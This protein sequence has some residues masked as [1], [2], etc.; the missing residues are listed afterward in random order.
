MFFAG[1]WQAADGPVAAQSSSSEHSSEAKS[2]SATSVSAAEPPATD[3]ATAT[4]PDADQQTQPEARSEPASA[5]MA[6]RAAL[7]AAAPAAASA[8]A[9][10]EEQP[11]AVSAAAQPLARDTIAPQPR[12]MVQQPDSKPSAAEEAPTA[13]GYHHLPNGDGPHTANGDTPEVT[14]DDAS[15]SRT[16]EVP[17]YKPWTDPLKKSDAFAELDALFQSR[18]AF[19]DGAMGTSIQRYNLEEEDYRGERYA[20]H[21][22]ELRGNNDL[23]VIT[24]PQARRLCC[25]LRELHRQARAKSPIW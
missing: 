13:N 7:A 15:R 23:L 17:E 5:S 20:K 2:A 4:A 25:Q 1:K 3:D 12:G 10:E 8:I 9:V 6:S 21:H 11:D 19:I 14:A 24:K 16:A 18:I 22:K